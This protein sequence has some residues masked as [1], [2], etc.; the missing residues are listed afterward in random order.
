[1]FNTTSALGHEY[2][3]VYYS[4]QSHR[5]TCGRCGSTTTTEAHERDRT[6]TNEYTC[7]ICGGK[8]QM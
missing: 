6:G 4:Q 8:I 7:P 3:W 2:A 5:R 1:M